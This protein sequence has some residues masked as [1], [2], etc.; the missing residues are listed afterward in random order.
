[1]S[2]SDQKRYQSGV[3]KLLHMMRWSR[4]DTL[5][6]VRELSRFMQSAMSA[7]MKAMH[8]V[9]KCCVGT[10]NRGMYLKPNA[11]WDGSADF[12][13]IINGTVGSVA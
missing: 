8:R 12:E 11:T 4:P 7:H 1:V 6:S 3:G 2:Y 10:P 5:N 13:F 9:M